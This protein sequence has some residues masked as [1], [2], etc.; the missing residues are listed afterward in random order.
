MRQAEAVGDGFVGDLAAGHVEALLEVR[1][2]GQGA[3]VALVGKRN[4]ERQGR[5][6]ECN[7]RGARDSTLPGRI[8]EDELRPRSS[9]SLLHQVDGRC[10]NQG[11]HRVR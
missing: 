6:V 9:S 7:G 2:L 4:G 11:R 5:V 8:D 1:V 10:G 3:A